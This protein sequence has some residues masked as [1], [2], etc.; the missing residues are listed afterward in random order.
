MG[1]EHAPAGALTSEVH[2]ARTGELLWGDTTTGDIGRS[3]AADIDPAFPGYEMWST[4]T[5]GTFACNGKAKGSMATLVSTSRPSW[6]FRV[7]WDGDLQDELLDG[8]KLDKWNTGRLVSLYNYGVTQINGTKATPNLSADLFGD[9]REEI[10]MRSNASDS[11]KI[12]TTTIPT[13]YRLHS[14]MHDPVYRAA[15]SW[16]NTGYNQPPHLG[17]LLSDT[18][19]WPTPSIKLIG[20]PSAPTGIETS[21]ALKGDNGNHAG[22]HWMGQTSIAVPSGLSQEAQAF[23]LLDLNG[24]LAS[25]VKASAGRIRPP[26]GLPHGVY[27]LRT[28]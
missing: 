15:I 27:L 12:F 5:A 17:F 2:D 16:Q 8:T 6:N 19:K 7:Y 10:V 13:T 20:Q 1:H 18:A 28:P 22:I 25:R 24:R 14:L 3:L 4:G 9:W 21:S 26:A 23:E 11:L